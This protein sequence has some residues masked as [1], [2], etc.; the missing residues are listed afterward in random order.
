MRA[1]AGVHR[2]IR[3]DVGRSGS[4]TLSIR[5]FNLASERPAIPQGQAELFEI[6]LAQLRQD[7]EVDIVRL[8]CA[9]ILLKPVTYCA[10][11]REDRSCRRV[12]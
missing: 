10:T 3:L 7:V 2:L 9:G 6:L 1:K 5:A 8:E 12:S 4:A 11:S